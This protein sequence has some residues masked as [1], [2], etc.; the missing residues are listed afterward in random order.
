MKFV[1]EHLGFL[2]AADHLLLIVVVLPVLDLRLDLGQKTVPHDQVNVG[3]VICFVKSSLQ[4]VLVC[5]V[6]R[7]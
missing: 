3:H 7:T 2:A 1:F 4:R 6:L 5:A